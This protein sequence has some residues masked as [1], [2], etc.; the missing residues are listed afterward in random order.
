MRSSTA[1]ITTEASAPP[2]HKGIAAGTPPP[3]PSPQRYIRALLT[4]LATALVVGVVL[5]TA[6]RNRSAPSSKPLRGSSTSVNPS[7][8]VRLKGTTEAVRMRAILTP[9]LSGQS[10]GSLTLTKLTSSG[11]NVKQ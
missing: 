3:T 5:F 1:D 2:D 4:V 11:T 9:V 6:L 7:S 10:V 8:S